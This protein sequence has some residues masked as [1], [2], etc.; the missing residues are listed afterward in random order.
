MGYAKADIVRVTFYDN[1]SLKAAVKVVMDIRCGEGTVNKACQALYED[2]RL[3]IT[4]EPV[5][6]IEN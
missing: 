3:E 2:D 5:I 6:I 1:A 4:T